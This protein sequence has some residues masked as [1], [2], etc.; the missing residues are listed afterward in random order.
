MYYYFSGYQN[1]LSSFM[2]QRMEYNDN[3]ISLSLGVYVFCLAYRNICDRIICFIYSIQLISIIKILIITLINTYYYFSG[4]HNYLSPSNEKIL[5]D[6][7]DGDNNMPQYGKIGL[8]FIMNDVDLARINIILNDGDNSR[9]TYIS[10][11]KLDIKRVDLLTLTDKSWV[12]DNIINFYLNLIMTR[13]ESSL[14]P[15]TYVMNTFFYPKLLKD[16]FM[17]IRRWTK[18]VDIFAYDLIFIPIHSENHW[19]ITII[20]F[21][22]KI[23]KYYDSLNGSDTTCMLTLRDYLGDEYVDKK[24]CV[25]DIS[26]WT[27]R[28]ISTIPIQNNS[29]DCGIY[30]CLF[31][32]FIS[33]DAEISFN[34]EDI[35]YARLKIMLEILNGKLSMKI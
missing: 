3:S 6:G 11:F 26:E 7:Y 8:N 23:I 32:E 35:P 17:S 20:D 10:K 25:L 16:G 13:G 31:A 18:G 5:H 19:T 15:K 2:E 33:R 14:L 27:M 1:Y 28:C 21:R 4:G 30:L 24:G 9:V 12:N 34:Q 29:F 22:T